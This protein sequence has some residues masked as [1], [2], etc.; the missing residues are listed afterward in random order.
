[1][2]HVG[3]DP[4]TSGAVAALDDAGAVVGLWDMPTAE[5]GAV[6]KAGRVR[7]VDAAALA[8]ILCDL[9]AGQEPAPPLRV[10]VERVSARPGQGVSSVFTFGGAY[11]CARAVVETLAFLDPA[12]IASHP[13]PACAT[14]RSAVN[15]VQPQA[16]R[17]SAGLP[18]GA[19]K[20]EYHAEAVKRWPTAD[21]WGIRKGPKLDRAAALLIADHARRLALASP[22]LAAWRP[23]HPSRPL[24]AR[25][26][27]ASLRTS[28]A[29][30]PAIAGASSP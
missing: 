23:T 1:M 2:I 27:R 15:L 17:R 19:G 26:S 18:A 28:C 9:W 10:T 25:R 20:P 7:I 16:W 14:G 29:S 3:I 8:R 6:T 12:V 22:S 24:P 11:H 4:G 21:L 13:E 5:L 30:S